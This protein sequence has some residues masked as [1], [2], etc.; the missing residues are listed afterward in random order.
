MNRTLTLSCIRWYTILKS[1]AVTKYLMKITWH[2]LILQEIELH[3]WLEKALFAIER[4]Q[5]ASIVL[6]DC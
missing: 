3:G 6:L 4:F 2:F 1:T 5:K